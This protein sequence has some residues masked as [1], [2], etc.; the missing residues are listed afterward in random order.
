MK[1]LS[2]PAAYLFSYDDLKLIT[3]AVRDS[4]E[5]SLTLAKKRTA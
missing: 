4:L 1:A 2:L 5:T 3:T